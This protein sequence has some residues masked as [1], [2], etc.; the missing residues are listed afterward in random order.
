MHGLDRA[1]PPVP[2]CQGGWII[3]WLGL[4]ELLHTIVLFYVTAVLFMP[5]NIYMQLNKQF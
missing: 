2:G 5:A 4:L 1:V 3:Q